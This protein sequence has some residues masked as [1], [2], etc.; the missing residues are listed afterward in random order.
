MN[1]ANPTTPNLDRLL[2]LLLAMAI[3]AVGVP[4]MAVG[5]GN[6]G[7]TILPNCTMDQQLVCRAPEG[8]DIF[9]LNGSCPQGTIAMCTT[10]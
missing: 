8:V 3:L 4:L 1:D 9:P 5:G 6:E 7:T 2:A 10:P